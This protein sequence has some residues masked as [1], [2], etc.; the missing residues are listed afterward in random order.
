MLLKICC[1]GFLK[2]G[3]N[4]HTLDWKKLVVNDEGKSSNV[5]QRFFECPILSMK[6]LYHAEQLGLDLISPKC[7]GVRHVPGLYQSYLHSGC[8]KLIVYIY[9]FAATQYMYTVY[10]ITYWYGDEL[11]VVCNLLWERL[12][13]VFRLSV[14][15]NLSVLVSF[16]GHSYS[17]CTCISILLAKSLLEKLV[18]YPPRRGTWYRNSHVMGFHGGDRFMNCPRSMRYPS[19]YQNVACA[20][21]ISGNLLLQLL[22]KITH[23]AYLR[24]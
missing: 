12:F 3:W 10:I 20:N 13:Q 7:V 9:S 24:I 4:N 19:F 8:C 16:S 15:Q 6:S 17:D 18:M 2:F 21:A 14:H 11:L 5:S 22:D 1:Y 23:L